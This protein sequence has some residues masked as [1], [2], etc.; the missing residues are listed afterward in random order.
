MDARPGA[1]TGEPSAGWRL[2]SGELAGRVA[3]VVTFS[4]VGRRLT[5]SGGARRVN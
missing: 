4:S 1:Q 2:P 5:C 3:V